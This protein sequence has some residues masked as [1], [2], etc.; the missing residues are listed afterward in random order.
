[1]RLSKNFALTGSKY[2]SH[3]ATLELRC[4]GLRRKAKSDLSSAL[5]FV[6]LLG[7]NL[8]RL[9]PRLRRIEQVHAYCRQMPILETNCMRAGPKGAELRSELELNNPTAAA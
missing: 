7:D 9:G 6:S 8:E 1:M 3:S 5:V 4:N 2:R